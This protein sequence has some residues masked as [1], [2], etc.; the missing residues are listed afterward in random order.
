MDWLRLAVLAS[1]FRRNSP[2]KS[3][4]QDMFKDVAMLVKNRLEAALAP[5][6]PGLA[7][8]LDPT[9]GLVAVVVVV[10][11]TPVV[12]VDPAVDVIP[13]EDGVV[14]VVDAAPERG[15]VDATRGTRTAAGAKPAPAAAPPTAAAPPLRLT[16]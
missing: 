2:Q 6:P 11:V 5:P 10:G 16:S 12:G 1:R 9:V 13:E 4:S 15:V 7:P 14:E 3:S 8:I